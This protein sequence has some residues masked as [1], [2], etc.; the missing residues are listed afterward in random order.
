M[1]PMYADNY[2]QFGWLLENPESTIGSLPYVTMK[3]KRDRNIPN[4]TELN[5]LQCQFDD[6]VADIENLEHSRYQ[7]PTII[8]LSIGIFGIAFMAGSVFAYLAGMFLL[9]V[10][11]ALPGFAGWIIPCFCFKYFRRQKERETAP[12]ID[13]KF[14]K[15]YEVCK[16]ANCLLAVWSIK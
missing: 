5:K 9:M 10:A 1:K 11:L 8:A 3:F 2:P 15:I 13:Q 7:K 14:D 12:V 4:K 6:L 16:K